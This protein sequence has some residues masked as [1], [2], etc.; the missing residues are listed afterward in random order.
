MMHPHPAI[1]N[2]HLFSVIYF[3]KN[4]IAETIFPA[5]AIHITNILF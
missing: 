4:I 3:T 2:K 5:S 1:N